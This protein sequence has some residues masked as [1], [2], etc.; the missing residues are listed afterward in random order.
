VLPLDARGACGPARSWRCQVATAASP[1]WSPDGARVAFV[2]A[3]NGGDAIMRL[4]LRDIAAGRVQAIGGDDLEVAPGPLQWS[5]DGRRIAFVQAWRGVQRVAAVDVETGAVE[6][7]VEPAHGQVGSLAARG[8]IAYTEEGADHPIELHASDWSGAAPRRLTDFNAWF[9]KRRALRAERRAFE[10]PDGRGG[11][12]RVE[13]WLL[14]PPEARG[15]LPLLVDVHGGPASYVSLQYATTP[16]WQVL[17]SRGWAVLMLDAVGSSSYGRAFA[18]RL[19]AHWGELD[20]PQHLAAV[21]ALRREGLA[22]ARTA[23]SGASYGGYLASWAIGHCDEFRAAVI[24]APVAN[25]ESHFG[26]SDSGYYADPYSMEGK[27]EANREL[28]LRL[29]PMARIES[30]CAPALLIQGKDDQRC[31]VGQSEEL[32]VKLLRSGTP[33]ELLLY[34]GG[35]HH[36]LSQG[37]P[38]HRLHAVRRIVDWLE[39]WIDQPREPRR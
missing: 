32:F 10:V 7:L 17:A 3:T 20:L 33:A 37:R 14:R 19:N 6:P 12:E 34:P 30:A 4:W 22:D 11:T 39:R 27:P 8:R 38:S 9:R 25:L 31:P 35:S 21:A 1:A 29:S 24:I 23:V 16:Y 28:M 2:G 15:P 18:E 5:A 26:T 36:V 13:G